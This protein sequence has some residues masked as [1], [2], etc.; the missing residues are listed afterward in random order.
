[1]DKGKS[2]KIRRKILLSLVLILVCVLFG[3]TFISYHWIEVN[4]Y[5]VEWEHTEQERAGGPVRFVVLSDLHAHQFMNDNGYLV[6]KVGE[7][8]PDFILMCGDFI[9][10][11]SKEHTG[12][13]RVVENLC[14]IA[15]V[16]FA[17]GNHELAYMENGHEE[18]VEDVEAAGAVVLDKEYVDISGIRIGGLYDYAFALDG[19]DEAANVEESVRVFLED[20]QKTDKYKI[21]M[22]H[23]PDSFIFGNASKYWDVDLVVSGHNHGGQVVL[24]FLGGMFGGDQGMFPKYIHG[25]YDVGNMKLFATSGLGSEWQILPRWNNRP[26]VAVIELEAK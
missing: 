12:L 4:E 25:M 1:M 5:Q 19:N 14:D 13:E 26:E 15:P 24:P 3:E 17:L 10:E 20:F 6:D 8:R 7:Q 22:S 23:R 11:D 16:Y 21:I 2:R 9:N 18:L